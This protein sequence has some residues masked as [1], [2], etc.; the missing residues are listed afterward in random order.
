MEIGNGATEQKK[1]NDIIDL[2]DDVLDENNPFKVRVKTQ[3]L[4][5]DDDFFDDTDQNDIKKVSEYVL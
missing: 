1:L 2:I 3:D 5:I 4:F